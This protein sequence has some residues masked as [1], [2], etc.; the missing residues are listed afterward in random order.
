MA[1]LNQLPTRLRAASSYKRDRSLSRSHARSRHS[2]SVHKARYSPSS[3]HGYKAGFP[4]SAAYGLLLREF[5]QHAPMAF[6]LLV[7]E[8]RRYCPAATHR[9]CRSST[10]MPTIRGV[11]LQ[12]PDLPVGDPFRD[13]HR[14][15]VPA[16]CRCEGYRND[17][18][19]QRSSRTASASSAS[20]GGSST[21]EAVAIRSTSGD[22]FAA[23]P[24]IVLIGR[25][26]AVSVAAS[27]SSACAS[28]VSRRTT[29]S[30]AKTP[31]VFGQTQHQPPAFDT[32]TRVR[33][34]VRRA[35][36]QRVGQ[37]QRHT[38]NF[39]PPR[40]HRVEQAAH[41]HQ[42]WRAPDRPRNEWRS[43]APDRPETGDPARSQVAAK[44]AETLARG[45]TPDGRGCRHP[46]SSTLPHAAAP[47]RR[48]RTG[49]RPRSR[50]AA[51]AAKS[52]RGRTSAARS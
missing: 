21:A 37:P 31:R 45:G 27:R 19:R 12:N 39:R 9:R 10:R 13:N 36:R 30:P 3:A 29:A 38:Q 41:R 20:P 35:G 43:S 17:T 52:D 32:Q 4:Q 11:V 14:A 16:S 40:R 28:R 23:G 50:P 6:A 25:R 7:R 34:Q 1:G 49:T 2:R 44:R 5:Q 42:E 26:G 47:P 46:T 22:R 48:F 33:E 18:R 15:S 8:R 51:P 24:F